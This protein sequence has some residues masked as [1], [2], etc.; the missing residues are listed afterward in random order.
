MHGVVWSCISRVFAG[1][2]LYYFEEVLPNCKFIS[3][4]RKTLNYLI[5]LHS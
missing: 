1:I 3:L 2:K 4:N 5:L